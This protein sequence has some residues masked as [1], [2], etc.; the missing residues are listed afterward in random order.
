MPGYAESPSPVLDRARALAVR[1]SVSRSDAAEPVRGAGPAARDAH[2]DGRAAEPGQGARTTSSRSR[3][4]AAL[5]PLSA[6]PISAGT[7]HTLLASPLAISGS[8]WR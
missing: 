5:T 7:T 8:F 3:S 4:N 2:P 1:P 6:W